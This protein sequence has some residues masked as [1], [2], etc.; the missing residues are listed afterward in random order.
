MNSSSG[1][2]WSSTVL[3]FGLDVAVKA[4]AILMLVLVIQS[5]FCRR[6]ALLG[7]AVGNAGLIGLLLLPFSSLVLPSVTIACLP[8]STSAPTSDSESMSSTPSARARP[9]NFADDAMRGTADPIKS[10]LASRSEVTLVREADAPSPVL[11]TPVALAEVSPAA[12]R[13]SSTTDWAAIAIAVYAFTA[14]VLL[15]RLATSILA[16]ARLRH[17]GEQVAEAEWTEAL[18]RWRRRLGI[19]RDVVLA[20]SPRVSIPLVLGWLRPTIV[21]PGSLAAPGSRGHADAV[22]LHE[23]SH[24]RRG[25]YLWNVLLRFVQALYW[26]HV[27]VWLLGRTIAAMRERACDDL[28]VHEMGGSSAYRDTLL[29]VASGMVHRPGLA[30]GLAMTRPS[31]LSQRLAEIERSNGDDRCLPRWPVRLAIGAMAI[32][33]ASVI[34]AVQL[35]RAEAR[36]TTPDDA[37]Q[38]PKAADKALAAST[39][40]RVFHLQVVAADTREPVP[41]ADVRVWMSFHNDWRKTDAQGR[42][43]IAHSTGPSDR[44]VG[45]DVW[46][47][48]RAMQRHNWGLDPNKP[49]PNSETIKLQPGETLGGLVQDEAGRPIVG[50]TIYLWS[51]NYKRKD[52]HELLYDLRAV[53]GP[54]GK[55]Q[56]SGAPETTGEMLGFQVVHPDFLSSRDYHQKEIIPKIADLRAGNAVSV[57]KKGAPIEGRVVDADGKPVAGARVLSTDNLGSM[58]TDVDN[59]AVSTDANGRFRTGQVKAGEWYLIAQAQG[60]GPGVRSVKIDT[61]V[62]Q[63]EIALDRP[64]VLKGR[65]VDSGG[66]PIAGAFVNPDTWR[67]FRCLRAFFWTDTDGRFRWDDAPNDEMSVNVNAQGYRGVFMQ[68]VTPSGEDVVF[69]LKPSLSIRGKL[70]DAQTKKRVDNATVD[71][72]AIDPKS[73]EPVK[74]TNLPELG[75]G[76]G[77]YQG[78]LNVNFP[79]TDDAYQIRVRSPGYQDFV[80]RTFRREEKA[81]IGYDIALLPGTTQLAGAVATVL[82]PDGKPLAG[83]RLL[84]IQYGGSLSVEDG[85]ANVSQGSKSREGRTGPDGRFAIPQYDK[86]WFVLIL[87]DDSYAFAGTE[88]LEKSPKIQA[89]AYARVEGQYLIGNRPVPHQQLELSGMIKGSTGSSTIHLDQKATTD[90]EG[91]FTFKNVIPDAGLRVARLDRTEGPGHIWSIGEA[92]RAEP[93]TTAHVTLGGKGRPIIGRIEPP[94]AWA[95]PVDFTVESMA[96]LETNRTL[97]DPLSLYRGKTSLGAEWNDWLHR[98]SGSPEGREYASRRAAVSVGLEPDGSFRIDDVSPGDYRLAIRVNG[99]AQFHVTATYGRDPGPF[100]R[101]VHTFTVPPI[102]GGRTDEPLNLGVMRLRPRVALKV[103]TP[104]PAFEVATVEDKRLTVP[105]DFRGKFLLIDFSTTWDSQSG[106]QIT[107]LNDVN[108]RFGKDPRFAILSVTFAA[109]NPETRKFIEDKGEPWRQAIVGPLSNAISLEYNIDDENVPATILIGPDGKVVAKDLWYDKIGKAVGEAL[110]RADR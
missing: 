11:S 85:V 29:A 20:W 81:V 37:P 30:L 9:D 55:W 10:P 61:A 107:R 58:H 40:G 95:K 15:S 42:L 65:V 25:D 99:K 74:W 105:G 6:R 88:A 4:T 84:E 108:G 76:V 50:A 21:L 54:D 38:S 7:S 97:P 35:V 33:V 5:V 19:G 60:R 43:E 31:K 18:E 109:D 72:S 79:I 53:T 83:A 28:C 71:Y 67:G 77:V 62:P 75:F 63:V 49:I 51:H 98:W 22:L 16:V 69:T 103:G 82:R 2:P 73:G 44:D 64:H 26:P 89:K 110:A 94:E 1:I 56:T 86:P 66:K 80:S 102:P 70:T 3:A 39:A 27:L 57:M 14:L 24:V 101:I 93:G 17:S 87:G 100:G 13:Q 12:S 34:G 78:D 47:K 96:G 32:T 46:G 106:I 68:R 36:V 45:V 41:D 90:P 91:R 52:P 48:G 23:L 8:P 92:V 59:F 104:A